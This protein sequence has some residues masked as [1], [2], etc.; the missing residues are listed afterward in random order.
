MQM[1]SEKGQSFIELGISMVFLL[2]LMAGV[3]DLGRVIF[4]YIA[5]RDAVQEG[6][7]YLGIQPNDCAG[8]IKRIREHTSGA[9]DLS[10]ANIDIAIDITV[11]GTTF[12]GCTTTLNAIS[13]ANA[14]R[15]DN[16]CPGDSVEVTATYNNFVIATPF[17]GGIV[18]GN[19]IDFD[20]Q[21]IDSIIVDPKPGVGTICAP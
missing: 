21:V 4:T 11:G 6:G 7:A 8:A 19:S 12:S 5:L 9:V 14:N 17:V 18:G 1:K 20:T 3:M 13:P 2:V 15:I 16:V 10:A